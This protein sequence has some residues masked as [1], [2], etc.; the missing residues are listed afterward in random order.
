MARSSELGFGYR[1][2]EIIAPALWGARAIFTGGI[3]DIVW[4]RQDLKSD[5][6]K[7]KRALID[8]LNGPGVGGEGG[9]LGLFRAHMRRLVRQGYDEERG[10]LVNVEFE[11]VL[12]TCSTNESCGY[13]Y[14]TARLAP[15]KPERKS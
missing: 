7:S 11:G 13:L 14:I 9:A 12:F 10:G 2:V 6:D 4:D 15:V 5:D 8:A 1:G 3:V